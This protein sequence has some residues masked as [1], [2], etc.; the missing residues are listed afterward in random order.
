MSILFDGQRAAESD[1]DAKNMFYR[2]LTRYCIDETS[3]DNIT[4]HYEPISNEYNFELGNVSK[5]NILEYPL[6]NPTSPIINFSLKENL[7]INKFLILF[8]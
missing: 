2:F 5:K 4:Y 6:L 3:C 7:F 8:F 1:S